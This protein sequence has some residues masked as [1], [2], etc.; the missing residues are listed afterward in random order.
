MLNE[1]CTSVGIGAKRLKIFWV[2]VGRNWEKIFLTCRQKFWKNTENSGENPGRNFVQN[3]FPTTIFPV[4]V[5][6]PLCSR[7]V[8]LTGGNALS[9]SQWLDRA[10]PP[11]LP[12]RDREGGR[13]GRRSAHTER[14]PAG[15]R[16]G[17][18]PAARRVHID[19][20]PRLL[21]RAQGRLVGTEEQGRSVTRL[22]GGRPS[23]GIGNVHQKS[24][25][26]GKLFQK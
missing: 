17:W 12:H 11:P 23:V 19:G 1:Q 21:S 18:G 24:N 9:R 14:L 16:V 25:Q 10:T 3:N 6:L 15:L 4:Q 5:P 26:T 7:N 20:A 8:P 2:F 22:C 13:A